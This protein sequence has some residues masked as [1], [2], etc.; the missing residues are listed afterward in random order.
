VFTILGGT[1]GT[2]GAFGTTIGTITGITGATTGTAS[3]DIS[4]LIN[5]NTAIRFTF[6]NNSYQGATEFIY[7]DDVSI[8]FD[9]AV[10]VAGNNP[11]DIL[12]SSSLY[13]LVGGQSLTV[14]NNVQVNN[15]FPS[16]QT[17]VT[18]TSYTSSVQLPIQL[19]SNPV[20]NIV[21]TPAVLAASVA[22]RL[23]LDSNADA[24]QDIGEPGIDNVIVTLKDQ[25]GTPV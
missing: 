17:S 14:T 22:G 15:P 11:P 6:P 4:A 7:I 21:A 1:A 24:I 2:G 5:A 25:F 13:T 18:N 19:A 10:A 16:G 8:T 12:S 20:T 9:V 3:F 23:W